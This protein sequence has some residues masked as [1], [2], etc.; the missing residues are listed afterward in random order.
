MLTSVRAAR[1]RVWH[2]ARTLLIEFSAESDVTVREREGAVVLAVGETTRELS[3]AR[4]VE[5]R[6][7]LGAAVAGRREFV[8]TAG[9]RRP[10]GS[11]VVERRG[12]DSPGNSVRFD[13]FEALRRLYDRLPSPVDA[14]AV[15][16]EGITGSRRH[17]VVRH[18]A[19]HPAF[20]CRVVSRSP[21][22]V[23]RVDDPDPAT[24]TDD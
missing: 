4:A 12:A 16:R 3:P 17:L 10:D 8:H 6:A 24:T 15:G 18:L 11:Y 21:L 5:L 23:R 2:G 13:S 19:E 1:P 9:R 14:E 22:R 20:G 7:A